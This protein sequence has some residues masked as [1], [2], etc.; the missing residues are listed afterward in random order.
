MHA[1][2]RVH[3]SFHFICVVFPN[4]ETMTTTLATP[5]AALAATA[6]ALAALAL[7]RALHTWARCFWYLGKVSGRERVGVCLLK[8]G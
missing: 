6:L 7:A 2:N 5:T 8:R 3:A 1:N 4:K